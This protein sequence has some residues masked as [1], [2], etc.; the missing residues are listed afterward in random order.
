MWAITA[1]GLGLLAS[2]VGLDEMRRAV[3]RAFT[4]ELAGDLSG[5]E[6]GLGTLVA[7]A[8][9]TESARARARTYLANLQ[10]RRRAFERH[11]LT[12]DGFAEAF[13]TLRRAPDRWSELMWARATDRVPGLSRRA[14][15]SRIRLELR[16]IE[17][18]DPD[19]VDR[20]LREALEGR[21]LRV[22]G[23]ESPAFELRLDLDASEVEEERHRHR[24]EAEGSYLLRAGP[25]SGAVLAHGRERH[26]ARRKQPDSARQW[27]SRRVLDDLVDRATFDV[28]LA[29]LRSAAST[30][31]DDG[32]PEP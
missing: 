11:G 19:E 7:T 14:A 4:A 28:R 16:R 21:G 23:G 24:A 25:P 13:A 31:G 27:A 3:D 1:L 32:E 30:P 10:R 17:G 8:T 12:R 15:S 20:A 26:E 5:A 18:A 29:L 22:R 2:D 9:L 6:A